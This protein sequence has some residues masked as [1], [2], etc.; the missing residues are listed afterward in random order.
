MGHL[1]R[2]L[3][4]QHERGE[5]RE[6]EAERRETPPQQVTT[7]PRYTWAQAAP[8][9]P[10][11]GTRA[12]ATNCRRQGIE[13]GNVRSVTNGRNHLRRFDPSNECFTTL[14]GTCSPCRSVNTVLRRNPRSTSTTR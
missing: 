7:R 2:D 1:L 4:P 3:L 14:S 12:A 9:I 13:D 6:G 11:A 5:Q 10:R 8:G